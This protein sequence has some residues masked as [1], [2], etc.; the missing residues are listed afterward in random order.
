MGC[1]IQG[2]E[3]V[4]ALKKRIILQDFLEGGSRGKQF[5]DI[6]NTD[7]QPAN[8]R[9]ASG[10]DR[11]SIEAFVIHGISC[12]FDDTQSQGQRQAPGRGL[13]VRRKR[14][15]SLPGPTSSQER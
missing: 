1:V 15:S 13:K 4:F 2:G 5:Q 7:A 3:D 11:D 14:D 12:D 6:R 10:F 9:A 8:A